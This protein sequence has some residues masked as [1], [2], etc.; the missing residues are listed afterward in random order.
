MTPTSAQFRAGGD[1][2][3]RWQL[4]RNQRASGAITSANAAAA[5]AN[6]SNH[7]KTG[8]GFAAA[9]SLTSAWIGGANPGGSNVLLSYTLL[10]DSDLNGS[11]D[12]SD[13]TAL[14]QNFNQSGMSWVN[15]DFNYDGVVNALDFN[16]LASNFGAPLSAP[17]WMRSCLSRH[18]SCLES[19]A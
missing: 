15:G 11:V 18:R 10:G 13:F 14:S 9:F 2:L 5:A 19:A 17:R 8:V 16:I 4:D 6:A 3:C 12:S 1:C 7:F